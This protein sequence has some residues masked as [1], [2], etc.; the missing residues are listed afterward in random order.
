MVFSFQITKSTEKIKQNSNQ[1]SVYLSMETSENKI[2]SIIDKLSYMDT[3]IKNDQRV[4]NLLKQMTLKEKIGQMTQ[5]DQQFLESNSDIAK[6]FLGSLLSGGGSVPKQNTPSAWADMVNRYQ[7]VALTTRLGIPIIYGV[8]AV[9]GHNN[10]VGATI[11]PH[12]IGLGCSNNPDLVAEIGRV[13]ALEVAATGIHWTFAPCLAVALDYRWGRTYESFGESVELVSNLSAP[14]VQGIQGKTLNLSHGILACAKHFVG[15]GGT[16]W[17]T[18]KTGMLDRGDTRITENE[19]RRIHL[20]GYL[21]AIKAGVGSIMASFNKWNGDYCHGNK[22]LLT[23]LLKDELGFEG[24]VVS[25]WEGVDQMPGDYKT[26]IITAINAGIDMVMVP[27]SAKWGGERFDYFIHLMIEAVKE[28]SIPTTRIDDAVS[29]I[30]NIKFRLGLFEHPLSNP[31]LLSHVGSTTHRE[32]ARRAVRESVVL[33]RNNGILPLKK[34]IP[35][36][37]VSGKSAN[38]IGLQCG[39]WTITWQGNSG[40]ITKGTTILEAIQNTVSNG[41]KVTYT[42]DGS[43]AVG[44]DIAV[45]VIGEKPYAEWEGDQEFLKLDKKDLETIGR[46]QK[47]EIPV[48]VVI[49]SGRPLIIEQEVTSWN[50]LLAAWLPGTEGQGVADVLFGDYNP[51]GRLSVSWPRNMSQIPINISDEEYDPLFEYG[52]GLQY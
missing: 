29:R 28:G 21:E 26:N 8:D 14:A 5:V 31:N 35:R 16:Q 27:G 2:T 33:L 38:D 18:G 49:I 20:P 47:S 10:V 22:Y 9:H 48:I 6:Y 42:K 36:I 17:G 23:N 25:D 50:A 11:F 13:T 15:D 3:G 34:D 1:L 52:F 37:H 7:K 51:T 44:S 19:L 32:L 4:I 46:I 24:F 39:G 12:N 30:L 40:P 43:G 41:T 45:V